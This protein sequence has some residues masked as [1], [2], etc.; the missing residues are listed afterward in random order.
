MVNVIE[1]AHLVR[2]AYNYDF[3]DNITKSD[4]AP[5]NGVPVRQAICVEGLQA[6]VLEDGTMILLGT[7]EIRDWFDYNFDLFPNRDQRHGEIPERPGE[8]G[9]K[10]HGGF[11][12]YARL[13]FIYAKAHRVTAVTGHSLGGAGA[14]II[15]ASLGIPTLTFGSPQPLA[16]PGH[17]FRNT[18]QMVN[19]CRRDDMICMV[20]PLRRYSHIGQTFWMPR[21][22]FDFAIDHPMPNYI[23]VLHRDLDALAPKMPEGWVLAPLTA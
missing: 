23:D 22:E 2:D 19:I 3:E 12:E 6:L 13:G 21:D 15:G 11:Y 18:H 7:N 14:Q 4:P 8:S 20:P 1:T 10:Y 16:T 5:M 17:P 9:A